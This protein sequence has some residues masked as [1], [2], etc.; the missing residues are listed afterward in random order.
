MR[1]GRDWSVE[2]ELEYFSISYI[3]CCKLQILTE[4]HQEEI[5]LIIFT[6]K[7]SNCWLNF[8][9]NLR[10][11]EALRKTKKSILKFFI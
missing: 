3:N 1:I 7:V 4:I 9:Q 2:T 11:D 6:L 10:T 5:H 8:G